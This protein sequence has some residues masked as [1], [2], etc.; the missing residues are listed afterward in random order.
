MTHS[1]DAPLPPPTTTGRAPMRHDARHASPSTT[2]RRRPRTSPRRGQERQGRPRRRPAARSPRPRP[3]R[4]RRSRQETQRQAKDLLDQGRAAAQGPDRRPAAEGRTGPHLARPELRGARRRHQLRCARPGARPAPA[5]LRRDRELRRPAA[6]PRAGRAARRG[7]QLRAPQ[8]RPVP[9][10]RGR[11][12]HRRRPADQRRPGGAQR[13][14]ASGSGTGYRGD[15]LRR[16]DAV[17][18]GYAATRPRAPTTTAPVTGE[19]H[20]RRLR[21]AAAAA[22]RHRAA[23]GQRR[24]AGRPAPAGTTRAGVPVGWA[25]P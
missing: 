23:R 21:P 17:L 24:P 9:A 13:L 3:T 25:D 8:A 11:C 18:L 4:P 15:Q 5:G 2:D 7:A 6:E 1:I 10:R 19:L 22:L 20:D 12:R 14:D 16:P